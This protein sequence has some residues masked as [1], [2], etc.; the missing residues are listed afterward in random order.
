MPPCFS[1]FVFRQENV[2]L[3]TGQPRPQEILTVVTYD[4]CISDP[5]HLLR[6]WLCDKTLKESFDLIHEL[7]VS[8]GL[9]LQDIISEVHVYATQ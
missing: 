5:T 7:S 4:R 3:C 1:Y 8:R 6:S 9:A 2:Y